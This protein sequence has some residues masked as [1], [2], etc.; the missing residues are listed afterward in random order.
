MPSIEDALDIVIR[1]RRPYH[2]MN[3]AYYGLIIISALY[4]FLNPAIKQ[5]L[6]GMVIQ[7]FTIGPL[8]SVGTAYSSGQVP[9][10]SI[11]TFLVNLALGSF[12]GITLPSLS[13][14]FPGILMGAY[15]AV[16]WG[17]LF[18][19]AHFEAYLVPH[20]LILFLVGQGYVLAML[21][22]YILGRSF[23]RQVKRCIWSFYKDRIKITLTYRV[24]LRPDTVSLINKMYLLHK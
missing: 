24:F 7:A 2:A 5:N 21:G 23:L 9:D 16:L 1:H 20:Y 3:L 11:L 8:S 13:I 14:P 12:M 17:I 19:P 15:R 18:S 6:N 10:A 4:T 22:A